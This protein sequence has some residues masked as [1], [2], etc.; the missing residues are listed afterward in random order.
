M[1]PSPNEVKAVAR[2]LDPTMS[3]EAMDMA[4]EAIEALDQ[5]R[6]GKDMW[7]MSA[8]TIKDGPIIN[9]GPWTTK[10]QALRATKQLAFA[11]DPN[12]TPGLGVMVMRMRT[13]D[14]L[15]SL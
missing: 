15:E 8:R 13:P 10:N 7:I 1:K 14:W 9:V 11:D 6:A 2:V 4:R 5:V 3:D 12:E